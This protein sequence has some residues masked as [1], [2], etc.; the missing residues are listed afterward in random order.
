MSNVCLISL[1]IL[2]CSGWDFFP[3]IE[4]IVEEIF[5][6]VKATLKSR[7]PRR[8]LPN[9][10]AHNAIAMGESVLRNT[11]L[12]SISYTSNVHPDREHSRYPPCSGHTQPHPHPTEATSKMLLLR[13]LWVPKQRMK[14][15]RECILAGR[16]EEIVEERGLW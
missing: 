5:I 14:N 12:I 8:Y 1:R 15:G 6:D 16:L 7:T 3:C 10:N 11:Q 13:V 4:E 2:Q 9:A